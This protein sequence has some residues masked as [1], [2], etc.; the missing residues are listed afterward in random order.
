VKRA[1]EAVYE[2]YKLGA[3][4]A[5]MAVFVDVGVS[6]QV[7]D[8]SEMPIRHDSCPYRSSSEPIRDSNGDVRNMGKGS[9]EA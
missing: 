1:K 5:N 6:E 4:G 9:E 7:W 8:A 2:S 3:G